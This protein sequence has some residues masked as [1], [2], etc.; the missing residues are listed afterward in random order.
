MMEDFRLGRI[1]WF[2]CTDAAGMG[3]DIPD[4]LWVVL[5]GIMPMSSAL[6]KQGR[7]VRDPALFGTAVWL[8][9]DWV[10]S[11]MELARVAGK[12]GGA[13]QDT[14]QDLVEDVS[15]DN[16]PGK[17]RTSAEERRAVL[18]PVVREYLSRSQG[19]QCMRTLVVDYLR[20]RPNFLKARIR[21][22]VAQGEFTDGRRWSW[23]VVEQIESNKPPAGRCCSARCCRTDPEVP[24]GLLSDAERE[25]VYASIRK[26][27]GASHASLPRV[28]PEAI[29]A[30]ALTSTHEPRSPTRRCSMA[31]RDVLRDILKAWRDGYWARVKHGNPML[32]RDWILDDRNLDQLVAK[33]HLIVNASTIDAAFVR[34]LIVWIADN[35]LVESLVATL[36]EF[37]AAFIARADGQRKKP[38]TGK[39]HATEPESPTQRLR[40]MNVPPSVQ[41]LTEGIMSG[42]PEEMLSS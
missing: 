7:A 22:G 42:I 37:R 2:F 32:S 11:P 21:D 5:Y 12:A 14:T 34:K 28:P 33:A 30:T 27:Y 23:E 26:L 3:C 1:R 17:D 24:V 8:I 35:D 25:R 4:V 20:P 38:N 15:D 41:R 9:E 19:D 18:E 40:S 39:V 29:A 10:F 31:E 16:T 13:T 6:Q 36:Q